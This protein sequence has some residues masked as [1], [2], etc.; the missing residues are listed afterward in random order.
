MLPTRPIVAIG[1]VNV[2]LVVRAPRMPKP[3]ESLVGHHF[4]M[5]LGGKASNQA[6]A[7]ARLG[8]PVFLVSSVGADSY[9]RML[10]RQLEGYGVSAD[11]ISVAPNHASGVAVIIIDRSGQNS[12][13]VTPG[14]YAKLDERDAARARAVISGAFALLLT[15]EIPLATIQAV[16]GFARSHGVLTILDPGPVSTWNPD[17]L[18]QIDVITPNETE[19]EAITGI[20]VADFPSAE[21]AARELLARG[22]KTV[23][24]KM[25]SSGALAADASGIRYVPAIRADVVDSTAAGDAFNAGYVVALAEGRSTDEALKFAACAGALAVTKAGAAP[26][27]PSREELDGLLNH[28]V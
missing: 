28:W 18:K 22:V 23:I 9:G 25:G 6:V 27:L 20:H 17:V 7:V 19:A 5:A 11:L 10:K 24:L 16:G 26:S 4:S 3:G 1:G 14:P 15:L 21:A 12:I 2:D 8:A 13:V